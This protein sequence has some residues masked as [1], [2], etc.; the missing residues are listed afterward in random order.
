MLSK[1]RSCP[2]SGYPPKLQSQQTESLLL[3]L[4]PSVWFASEDSIFQFMK[5]Y[6]RPLRFD[7]DTQNGSVELLVEFT[8]L[9]CREC[10]YGKVGGSM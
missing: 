6:L 3:S 9:V 10:R 7:L 4:S 2:N 1:W 5:R 8:S